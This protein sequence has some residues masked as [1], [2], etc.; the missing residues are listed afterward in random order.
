[1]SGR[2][3]S[4][5]NR[6]AA[7]FDEH[8]ESAARYHGDEQ[9]KKDA[10][11][12]RRVAT[13]LRN[14]LKSFERL[15]STQQKQAMLD[16]ASTMA[17]LAID[18]DE[19]CR[20]ARRRLADQTA[21]DIAR[22]TSLADAGAAERWVGDDDAMLVEVRELAAF[23]D[24]AQALDVGAWLKQRHPGCE[25]EHFPTSELPPGRRLIDMLSQREGG[26][27]FLLQLRRRG[28][29]YVAVLRDAERRPGR[30]YRGMWYV[31]LDDFEAW[32]SWRQEV[33]AAI[34]PGPKGDAQS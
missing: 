5:S 29:E 23:V 30:M 25:L 33:L 13:G 12:A 18:L 10:A 7:L 27:E 16:A 2:K 6:A 28:A 3:V 14:T 1:M 31:G 4:S 20:L 8:Y 26:A 9:P 34:V 22:R 15:L 21:A 11:A 24:Q 19:A 32:R 17:S